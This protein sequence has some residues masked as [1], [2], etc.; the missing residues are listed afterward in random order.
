M[1]FIIANSS[2]PPVKSDTNCRTPRPAAA[3][4]MAMP[5]SSS[6]PAVR[7]AIGD[8]SEER[9][10][11]VR[12]VPKPMAPASMAR[13]AMAAMAWM[14]ASVAGSR[15]TPRWPITNTLSAACGSWLAI[16]TSKRRWAKVSRYSG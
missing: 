9:W 1:R 10:F 14:S 16:S 6:S 4:P 7:V 12:E 3:M 8:P 2:A 5:V 13:L 15:S 11:S